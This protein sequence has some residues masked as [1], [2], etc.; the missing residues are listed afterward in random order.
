[1]GEREILDALVSQWLHAQGEDARREA[2][3]A[4]VKLEALDALA[5]V[6][7]TEHGW[8][9]HKPE[10][11]ARSMLGPAG[12]PGMRW[13]SPEAGARRTRGYWHRR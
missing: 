9:I 13:H 7:R 3:A 5:Y 2:E 10:Q 4:A 8:L 12:R 1:M 6:L 11:A